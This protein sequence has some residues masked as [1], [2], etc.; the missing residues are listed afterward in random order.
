MWQLDN[1]T[2]FAAERTWVRGRDGA[3]IWLVAVKCTFEVKPDG[4]T[5]VAAEQPPVTMAPEYVDPA[6]P[7]KSSLKYDMDLMRTK[8]ATDVL[9]LGHAYAP[10]GEAVAALDVGFRVGPVAKV[11]RV[12]GDRFWGNG[13]ISAAAPFVKMP[14]VY[15]RAFGGFD[16]ATR[17]TD[18]PQWDVRNPLGTGFALSGSSAEGQRLPNIEY[19][20]RQIGSWDDR[21]EPAG[22][23]PVCSHWQPRVRLAGTYDEKWQQER[24]PLLP[25]DFDDRHYQCAPA[26]QQAPGF[27][28]G[29]EPAVL[30]NLTPSGELRFT[31]PRVFLGLETF[32][33]DG[34]RRMHERP[35]L[36]TVI[37]E[38]D[39]LLVSLVWHSALPCHSKVYKLEKTRIFQKALLRAGPDEAALDAASA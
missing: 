9:A 36:H 15:E 18:K 2:P 31:V 17:D 28:A 3:E 22:F 16:P 4:T 27:L 6:A 11:L 21:P 34:E 25:L 32:F 29:G 38:P 13:R 10:G 5:E 24:F 30:L 14:I 8:V 1:R 33:H 26:D 19:A 20:D 35:K 37:F 7:A 12:F 23:G 39:H